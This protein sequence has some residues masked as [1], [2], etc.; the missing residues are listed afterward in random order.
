M[1]EVAPPAGEERIEWLLLT[2]D[3]LLARAALPG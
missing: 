1:H 3:T 2:S